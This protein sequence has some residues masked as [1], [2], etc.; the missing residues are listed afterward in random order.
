LLFKDNPLRCETLKPVRLKPRLPGHHWG[1]DAGQCFTYIHFNRLIIKYDL[2]AFYISGSG[3]EAP[4]ILSQAYLE[5]PYSEVYPDKRSTGN[6]RRE[7][8]LLILYK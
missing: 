2:N 7:V 8:A 6:N 5:G 4:S 3:Y 1:S